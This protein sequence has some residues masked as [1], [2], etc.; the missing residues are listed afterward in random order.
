MTG[1]FDGAQAMWRF[2]R[3]RMGLGLALVSVSIGLTTN[4]SARGADAVVFTGVRIFDGARSVPDQTVVVREGLIASVT[5]GGA[6]PA[7]A[8]VI[9]GR[10][11]TLLPGL[12]DAHTHSFAVDQLRAAA[13]F[14]VTTELDMFTMPSFAASQRAEQAAGDAVGR[15][16]LFSAGTLVTAPGGHG[17]EY[18]FPIPTITGPDQADA[19][20]AARVA[21]GSDYIKIVYDDGSE[22]G[23]PWKTLDRATL[24]AVIRAAKSR[25]KLAVV[26][27]LARVCPRRAR[28]RR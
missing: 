20:V 9:D 11:K 6:I 7:G 12:I 23:L 14:G 5:A 28:C 17:T 16:D 22:I 19:F 24:T 26:H 15:A 3:L 2:L 21:E 1:I 10:G 13:I 8:R 25:K 18:G 4:M 27:V